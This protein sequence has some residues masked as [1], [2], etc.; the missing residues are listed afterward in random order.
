MATAEEIRVLLDRVT[1]PQRDRV[2][3]VQGLRRSNAAAPHPSRRFRGSRSDQR[4][5]AVYESRNS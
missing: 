2:L 1:T 3:I 5:A 4:R